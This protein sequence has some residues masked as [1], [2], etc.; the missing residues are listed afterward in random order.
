MRSCILC[1]LRSLDPSH[2]CQITTKNLEIMQLPVVALLNYIVRV[3][4]DMGS[5]CMGDLEVEKSMELAGHCGFN[6]LNSVLLDYCFGYI[7]VDF[8]IEAETDLVRLTKVHRLEEW[9]S[10]L[11]KEVTRV[12]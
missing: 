3:V 10:L 5:S 9:V 11:V 8:E 6:M 12:L 4:T 2:E 7:A 1:E